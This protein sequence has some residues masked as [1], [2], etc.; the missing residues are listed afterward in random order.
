MDYVKEKI[1]EVIVNGFISEIFK[2]VPRDSPYPKDHWWGYKIYI[3]DGLSDSTEKEALSIIEY[4]YNEG[5]IPDRRVE[6]T[7]IRGEDFV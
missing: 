1:A 6:Y 7:V 2:N 3:Y 5:F 4:L